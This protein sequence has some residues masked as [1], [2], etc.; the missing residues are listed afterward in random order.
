[1]TKVVNKVLLLLCVVGI[2]YIAYN[3]VLPEGYSG[4]GRG[5]GGGGRMRSN[6]AMGARR[7]STPVGGGIHH[8]RPYNRH[9]NR[10][11]NRHHNRS[12]SRSWLNTWYQPS[13]GGYYYD[14]VAPEVY[15]YPTYQI[16]EPTKQ[17]RSFYEDFVNFIRWI[18]GYPPRQ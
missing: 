4:R 6:G 11:Y 12:Y 10:P 8:N 9:H 5:G 17:S 7:H 15:L 1:M 18:F 2:L 16:A 13:S 14:D 3:Y